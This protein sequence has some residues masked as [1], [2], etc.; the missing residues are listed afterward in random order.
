MEV[1]HSDEKLE[2]LLTAIDEQERALASL[3]EKV[4]VTI[5]GLN[6]PRPSEPLAELE[7]CLD[8]TRSHMTH[9]RETKIRKKLGLMAIGG[10]WSLVR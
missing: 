5:R 4:T 1:L 10:Y 6:Q 8:V 3:L 2:A 7:V 9:V